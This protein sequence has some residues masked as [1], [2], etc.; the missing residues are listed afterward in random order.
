MAKL[1]Q[2][3]D[4]VEHRFFL[5][6]RLRNGRVKADRIRTDDDPRLRSRAA[7]ALPNNLS[8]IQKKKAIEAIAFLIAMS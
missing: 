3:H 5:L 7:F 2:H 4:G 8:R 1:P 6:T